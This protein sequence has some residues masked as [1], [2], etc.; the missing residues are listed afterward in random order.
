[1]QVLGYEVEHLGD[2]QFE[3]AYKL[4][5]SEKVIYLIRSL[6]KLL[7]VSENGKCGHIQHV[8]YFTD[9]DGKLAPLGE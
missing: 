5:K 2:E 9:K 7:P 6:D 3:Y 8:K 1:M 4:T